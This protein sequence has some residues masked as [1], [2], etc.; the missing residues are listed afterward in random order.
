[1]NVVV[2]G[3]G[4]G[5]G[6]AVAENLAA[7][8]HRILVCGRTEGK[9]RE[10]ASK[11]ML[12]C[13]CDVADEKQ[14]KGFAEY[15]GK[16]L[17]HVDVLIN[18]A[19]VQGE[20]GRFDETDSEKWLN[21]FK[22]NMFGVYLMAKHMLPLILK[23]ETRRII[24][25]S[26]GGAFNAF[27]NYSAYAVSKAGV[28]RF[29]ENIAEEL[30]ELGV[31]VNCVA[32]GF[33]ATGIHGET[34]EAGERAGRDYLE[35]TK[36]KLKE[37]SVPMKVPVACVRFLIHDSGGLTGKT[38]SAGFDPWDKKEF[39]D[40]IDGLNESDLYTMRRINLVNLDLRD[41]LRKL[42]ELK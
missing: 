20:I 10:V 14:V 19:G 37:G 12:W 39:K 2:T 7:D 18:A 23:S 15:A 25:F 32:P 38:L 27:P 36:Q 41:R 33:V 35:F 29:T 4:S 17:G 26:G 21:T 24:N 9:L 6:A 3:G 31:A 30:R 11:G 13:V 42:G 40:F 22:T 1:M 5:I 16:E 28:I 8:G 34:L